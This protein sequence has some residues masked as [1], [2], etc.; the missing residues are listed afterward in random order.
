MLDFYGIRF[1]KLHSLGLK[2]LS[3]TLVFILP[4]RFQIE[5]Q[6]MF[7]IK[8]QDLINLPP[9]EGLWAIHKSSEHF[10]LRI[11]IRTLSVG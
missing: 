10:D 5:K 1:S 8:A 2:D 11:L 4:S 6:A 7:T 3:K 9:L